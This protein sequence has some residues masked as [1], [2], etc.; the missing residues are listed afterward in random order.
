MNGK[1][2]ICI[3]TWGQGACSGPNGSLGL[4]IMNREM[5]IGRSHAQTAMWV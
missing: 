5:V 3:N 1:A 2:V 4:A